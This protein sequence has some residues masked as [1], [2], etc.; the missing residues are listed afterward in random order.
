MMKVC[1]I[2]FHH[3]CN[4]DK[5]LDMSR[6]CQKKTS[7][8]FG[9]LDLDTLIVFKAVYYSQQLIIS[10]IEVRTYHYTYMYRAQCHKSQL[11]IQ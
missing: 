6:I 8:N 11:F 10:L 7:W 4:Q 5:F 2:V 3:I 9:V 1:Y